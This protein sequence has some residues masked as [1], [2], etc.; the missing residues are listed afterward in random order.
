MRICFL[1]DNTLFTFIIREVLRD[2]GLLILPPKDQR[3]LTKRSE[4]V[5]FQTVS[6][7]FVWKVCIQTGTDCLW[8]E[9]YIKAIL[10]RVKLNFQLKGPRIIL[11]LCFI[12]K[13]DFLNS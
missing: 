4:R 11:C 2:A 3:I 1:L 8:E 9:G 5:Y 7:V 6:G 13:T 12:M 10:I